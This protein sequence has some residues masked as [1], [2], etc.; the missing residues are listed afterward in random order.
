MT[1]EELEKLLGK[2]Q[3]Q[4]TT[5]GQAIDYERYPMEAL[6]I[7]M[8]WGREELNTAHDIFEKWEKILEEG[9]EMNSHAFEKD[10]ADALNLNYQGLKPVVLSLYRNGQWTDVCE[11]YVDS[12]NGKASVEYR[13]IMDRPR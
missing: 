9:K 13:E 2:I 4:I 7:S 1:N 6:V 11:A 12:F 10:F 5:I 3:F 8:D